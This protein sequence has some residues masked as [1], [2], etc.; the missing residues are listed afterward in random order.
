MSRGEEA[1]DDIKKNSGND[2]I[3]YRQADISSRT[4][5]N[6]LVEEMKEK[7]AKSWSTMQPFWLR[8]HWITMAVNYFRHFYLTAKLWSLLRNSQDL[9]IVNVSSR[10][11]K[12]KS[13]SNN[14]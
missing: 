12:K 9:R 3:E 1:V 5:I 10:S 11:H 6:T 7:F 4:S 8:W 13:R 14:Q 2:N